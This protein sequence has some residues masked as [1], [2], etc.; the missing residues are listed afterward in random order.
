[1]RIP[2]YQGHI[3]GYISENVYGTSYSTGTS[4]CLTGGLKKGE[5]ASRERF[6]SQNS[7][8]YTPKNN[9][10]IADSTDAAPRTDYLEYCEILNQDS[11]TTRNQL[12]SVA[13]ESKTSDNSKP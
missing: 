12:P 11:T 9:R 6:R 2:G 5:P 13:K 10:R 1:M 4:K 3:R 7:K 8:A